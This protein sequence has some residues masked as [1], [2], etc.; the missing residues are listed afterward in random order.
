MELQMPQ[1]SIP[2]LY[3]SF[4]RILF[5][6]SP[7]WFKQASMAFSRILPKMMPQST[8]SIFMFF[9]TMISVSTWIPLAA[10]WSSLEVRTASRNGLPVLTS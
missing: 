8:M 4:T 2:F 6:E 9:T 5:S 3:R 1:T 7:L 10:A